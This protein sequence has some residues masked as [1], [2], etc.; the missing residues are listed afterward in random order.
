MSEIILPA[1]LES[2]PEA[3]AFLKKNLGPHYDDFGTHVDL[4]VEELLVNVANYAYKEEQ[5]RMTPHVDT[6]KLGCR[7]VNM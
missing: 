4:A 5:Y 7:W 3:M 6:L 2:I 1:T